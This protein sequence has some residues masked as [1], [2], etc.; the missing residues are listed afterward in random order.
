MSVTLAWKD[1]FLGISEE[2][3]ANFNSFKT[4]VEQEAD[5]KKKPLKG[6]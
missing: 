5:A 6:A 4:A 2:F 1:Q 3:A